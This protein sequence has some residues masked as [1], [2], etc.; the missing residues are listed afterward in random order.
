MT[1]S[2]SGDPSTSDKDAV[3]FLVGDT[4]TNDQLAQDEEIDWVLTRTR[5]IEGAAAGVARAIAGLFAR[6][7]DGSL[8]DQDFSDS[9]RREAYLALARTLDAMAQKAPTRSGQ[10]KPKPLI[11]GVRESEMESVREDTDRV[12]PAFYYGLFDPHGPHHR[13]DHYHWYH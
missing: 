9:Q 7:V 5:T 4:D 6:E 3:R 2:Y 13:D 12:R 10:N 11:T 1:W 8:E